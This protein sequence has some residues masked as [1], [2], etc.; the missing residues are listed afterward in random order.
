MRPLRQSGS[1]A[2][3]VA[4][5]ASDAG[6]T[7]NQSASAMAAGTAQTAN[8]NC[9]PKGT[10]SNGRVMLGAITSPTSRPLEEIGIARPIRVG[11]QACA[12]LGIAD[13]GTAMPRADTT[14]KTCRTA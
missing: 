5:A 6:V 7:I 14:V 10:S 4:T 12:R 11:N 1:Q 8:A 9:Q 13:G 2:P 3:A